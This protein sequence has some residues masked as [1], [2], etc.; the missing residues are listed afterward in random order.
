MPNTGNE[1]VAE[2]P[3]ETTTQPTSKTMS[4]KRSNDWSINLNEFLRCMDPDVLVLFDVELVLK[5]PLPKE[6]IGTS[7]GLLEFK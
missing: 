4:T 2:A 6:S 3:A 7:L 1:T 5:Y